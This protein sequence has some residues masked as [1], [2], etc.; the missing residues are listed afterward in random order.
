MPAGSVENHTATI[1]W[2]LSGP[3]WV[4]YRARRDLLGQPE[5]EA[6]VAAARQAALEDPAVADLLRDLAAWPG[7]AL[8][9]HNDAKHLLHKLAFLADLGL[10]A[11]AAGL[12]PVLDL[13][14]AHR[15]G[16]GAFQ[17]LINIPRQFGGSGEDSWGWVLCDAPTILYALAA[18]GLERDPRVRQA[19]THLAGLA[20]PNGWPCAAAPELGRFR[21]PG[22]VA[23]PCPYANLVALKALLRYPEWR[24]SEACKAGAEALLTAWETRRKHKPYLFGMGTD[25]AKLKAPL[26]WYDLL[27]VVDVLS[28]CTWLR[29][30]PRMHELAELLAAKA[31][32]RGRYSAE[33]IWMAWKGWEFGQKK[34]PSRWL[35]LVAA[36]ALARLG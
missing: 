7:E 4:E 1:D 23:D 15:S 17:I 24:E 3:A 11:D 27:H 29:H 2:L 9:R 14:L 25:F 30:D 5:G 36:R 35:T 19:A 32:A 18:F 21:G 16:E 12:Q 33:S 31:D 34:A 8:K 20:R 6:Q 26:I 28:R 22:R 10:Q 13:I